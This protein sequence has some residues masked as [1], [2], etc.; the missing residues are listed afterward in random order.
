MQL[1]EQ[2]LPV[3]SNH[4]VNSFHMWQQQLIYGRTG[5]QVSLTY[6]P[7]EQHLT[8]QNGKIRRG[9]GTRTLRSPFALSS[10]VTR[11]SS[12]AMLMSS[13]TKLL[14]VSFM[15]RVLRKREANGTGGFNSRYEHEREE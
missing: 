5:R 13:S 7:H 8:L 6:A 12:K 4:P 1:V 10:A 2:A 14:K 3:V 11:S 9:S 15:V